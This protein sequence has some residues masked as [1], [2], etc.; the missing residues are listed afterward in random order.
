[1]RQ[2]DAQQAAEKEPDRKVLKKAFDEAEK[3]KEAKI[4]RIV[5]KDGQE[6]FAA[7]GDVSSTDLKAKATEFAKARGVSVQ[8][9]AWSTYYVDASGAQTS[10]AEIDGSLS[11]E[12]RSTQSRSDLP[13][14]TFSASNVREISPADAAVT[15]N[16]K[17]ESSTASES[18]LQREIRIAIENK[19][20]SPDEARKI[21]TELIG[22]S[23]QITA[24][25]R[26]K[27]MSLSE[28]V[29]KGLQQSLGY[30]GND[31]D[32]KI[33]RVGRTGKTVGDLQKL[34]KQ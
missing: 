7:I 9:Q 22:K 25:A 3:S 11:N 27:W 20:I 13:S 1:M 30:T 2:L 34:A 26:A 18:P 29:A 21:L 31:V 32:G 17:L 4:Y 5:D 8:V 24:D 33:A 12:D 6:R 28:D 23:K 10:L 16:E 14:Y 15:G 19:T